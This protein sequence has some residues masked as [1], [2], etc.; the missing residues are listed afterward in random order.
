MA[1]INR[2]DLMKSSAALWV[3]SRMGGFSNPILTN[4]PA[5]TNT[6]ASVW[7]H[8]VR[9][10]IAEGYTPPFYPTLEYDPE[11]TTEIAS[12]LNCDSL[13]YPVAS[14]YAY[15]PTESGYPLDPRM[16]GDPMH[17]TLRSLR[18]RGL[19]AIAYIPLNH[20]FMSPESHD[21]RYPNWV[22]R[23][24]NGKPM[25][26][27]HMG[28][29]HLLE[30]C[31]NSPIRHLYPKIV[32]EV[33]SWYDFDVIY[34]DGPYQGLEH[35]GE[36]CYCE[37]CQQAFQKRF[38]KRI[39]PQASMTEAEDHQYRMWLSDVVV[40][41]FR[42]ICA[43]IRAEKNIPILYNNSGL[44]S[45]TGQW[46][47]QCL[48]IADGFMFE[49]SD[50]FGLQLGQSTGKTIWTYVGNY[51][52]YSGT[53]LRDKAIRGWYCYPLVGQQIAMEAAIATAA[54]AGCKYWGLSRFFYQPEAPTT[55]PE[56]RYLKAAFDF[57]VKHQDLLDSLQH[58]AQAGV[59]VSDQTIKWYRN[60]TF[61]QRGYGN[62]F[63]GAYSLFK[64]LNIEPEPFLDWMMS[65]EVLSRYSVIYVP[66][67]V[68]L[69][70]AQCEM[71]RDY[72][73]NGGHMIATNLTSTAD[74]F[75][76][77]RGNFALA[78]MF[79]AS[80]ADPVPYEYPDL[81]LK[82]AK[83]PLVPQDPEIV[84]FRATSGTVLAH[85]FSRGK[86]TE[87][88][89]A[90]TSHSFGKGQ[91]LYI[92][93][94]LEAVFYE[95]KLEPLLGFLRSLIAPLIGNVQTYQMNYIPGIIAHRMVNDS[96]I[97]LHVLADLGD[98]YVDYCARHD[99]RVRI[100]VPR[101]VRSVTLL[102]SGTT[103]Q[104]VA[105]DEWIEVVV[106]QIEIYEAVCVE[107]MS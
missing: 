68:C 36:Y 79:G 61:V 49:G 78:D 58:Q 27:A 70:E 45:P 31:I 89:P 101:S 69:S 63:Q 55:Y 4:S 39:P 28:F 38:G 81:Y 105:K 6:P 1:D 23:Y 107:L 57:Q 37:H 46:K 52:E 16:K 21:P 44:L 56:G 94:G 17:D 32:H 60:K 104:F 73:R 8:H 85:T 47:D 83:G 106:P 12:D 41:F 19:R 33:L 7:A 48:T 86:E 3:T 24:A 65:P 92:G 59:V 15:F 50:L 35:M 42:D 98:R 82:T 11:R 14:Y 34:F 43:Q 93:S 18:K 66:N 74:E 91:V 9:V 20:P 84:K 51:A 62:Y 75:G 103:V 71:L 2:R 30:G 64:A 13:R 97:V 80:L 54:G 40:G 5:P 90:I 29:N 10:L 87:L 26:T 77:P 72:V 99:V 95:T 53:H 76:K 102:R 96:H 88:G 25:I 100:R 67:A 22:K